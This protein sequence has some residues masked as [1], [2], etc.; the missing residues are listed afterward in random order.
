MIAT[1][2]YVS[3]APADRAASLAPRP[4]LR[5]CAPAGL[6]H[7]NHAVKVCAD[8]E[9]RLGSDEERDLI[10]KLDSIVDRRLNKANGVLTFNGIV[11]SVVGNYFSNKPVSSGSH[12]GIGARLYMTS[13]MHVA[14]KLGRDWR[15]IRE[16]R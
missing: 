3:A 13:I 2:D 4:A 5:L 7:P 16:R 15:R 6:V 14:G 1:L 10:P 11:F 9:A 12:V 8:L